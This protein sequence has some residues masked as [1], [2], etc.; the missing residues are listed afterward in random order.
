MA[1]SPP[2]KLNTVSILDQHITFE[3]AWN[4]LWF[5]LGTVEMERL[6]RLELRQMQ[7]RAGQKTVPE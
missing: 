5:K 1:R 3:R 2:R 6:L 4:Q 7:R